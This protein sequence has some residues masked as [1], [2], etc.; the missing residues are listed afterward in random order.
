[1][2]MPSK[3][4]K[5]GRKRGLFCDVCLGSRDFFANSHLFLKIKLS[6]ITTLYNIKFYSGWPIVVRNPMAVSQ[7]SLIPLSR[8]LSTNE[9]AKDSKS[10]KGG[11]TQV[12]QYSITSHEPSLYFLHS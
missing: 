5:H 1:M 4:D 11:T 7:G 12:K 9:L 10:L 3:L 2:C 6:R 8:T